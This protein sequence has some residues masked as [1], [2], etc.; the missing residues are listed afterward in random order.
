[1]A[2]D[3]LVKSNLINTFNENLAMWLSGA[4]LIMVLAIW[5]S[6]G[7]LAPYAATHHMA[8]VLKPCDYLASLDHPHFLGPVNFLN[9]EPVETW[10]YNIY[11]RRILYPVLALPFFRTFGFELGGFIANILITLLAVV[12]FVLF[13][14]RYHGLWAA[15]ATAALLV[16]YPGIMYWAGLPYSQAIIV[17]CYLISFSFLWQIYNSQRVT[18]IL[19]YSLGIGILSLGYDL[20]PFLLPSTIIV[21]AYKRRFLSIIGVAVMMI[22]PTVG[23]V[24][25]FRVRY[26][27][28]PSNSNSAIYGTLIWAYLSPESLSSW[29]EELKR[30]PYILIH[31]FFYSNF[32]FIPLL[33]LVTVGLRV[34]KYA[35]ALHPVEY[36]LL[37]TG[38][39][40]FLFNNA[41]P[42]YN[43]PWQMRGIWIARIYQPVFVVYLSYIAR[44]LAATKLNLPPQ[45]FLVLAVVVTV[46]LNSITIFGPIFGYTTLSAHSYYNFYQH[47]A[48]ASFA[49]N[50]AKYGRRPIGFCKAQ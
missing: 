33:F 41:A 19:L 4:L 7:T 43:N 23:L 9:G 2:Q 30:V 12:Y 37:A 13:I 44:C 5:V 29:M 28:S 49:T 8:L 6:S 32:I 48:E 31:N 22:L 46:I 17:P 3:N 15:R 34:L 42:P 35:P 45:R 50:L 21:L 24:S 36:A 25:L 27:I 18:T 39:A 20:L 14:K 38:L 11:L 26:G 47:D 10:Q 16:T 1:M 40:L